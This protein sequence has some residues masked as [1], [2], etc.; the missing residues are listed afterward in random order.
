MNLHSDIAMLSIPHHPVANT[1]AGYGT[2]YPS[3]KYLCMS[4]RFLPNDYST[5]KT[6][7]AQKEIQDGFLFG[8]FL[9]Y[10]QIRLQIYVFYD[11][12]AIFF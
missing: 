2:V 5:S 1:R 11:T 7:S 9:S 10:L 3:S 4:M 6:G 8:V 12:S